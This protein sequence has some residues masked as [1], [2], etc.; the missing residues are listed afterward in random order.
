MPTNEGHNYNRYMKADSQF[1]QGSSGFAFLIDIV[2]RLRSFEGCP[3]DLEQTH[4]SLKRHLLEETYEVLEAIDRQDPKQLSEELG[5]LLVQVVFHADIAKKAGEFDIED[6]ATQV[7]HKL[8]RRHP[9]VFGDAKVSDAEE[10]E[11][12]WE[13]IKIA[14]G[15]RRSAV[16]GIPSETPALAY[17]QVMQD[18]AKKAGF[19]W[20]DV[21][22]VLAKVAEEVI[23]IGMAKNTAEKAKE[24]GD[25][26]FSL[27]NL[28][29]WLGIQAEDALR[30]ANFR[31]KERY[32]MMEVLADKKNLD[33][34]S[35]SLDKKERL[36]EKAKKMRREEGLE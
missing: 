15:G 26:I 9:H 1:G 14:E 23:E 31:F 34:Y 29:R 19:D 16:E 17:A 35:L 25:L 8:I 36:W 2:E 3:W 28:A 32:L 27:V 33:F 5:D 13:R 21:S 4:Q 10:V 22:G 30:Q 24:L 6:V 7:G 11:N 20:N 12:N 18:R